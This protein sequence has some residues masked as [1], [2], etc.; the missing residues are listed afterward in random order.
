M[1]LVW[2][3][4]PHY[5]SISFALYQLNQ[6]AQHHSFDLTPTL[7]YE[8]SNKLRQI[9]QLLSNT[10]NTEVHRSANMPLYSVA[11]GLLLRCPSKLITEIVFSTDVYDETTLQLMC[12]WPKALICALRVKGHSHSHKS[13]RCYIENSSCSTN[14]T[15]VLKRNEFWFVDKPNSSLQNRTQ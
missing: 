3:D 11:L 10:Y 4:A 14:A 5:C 12:I 2:H 9:V 13:Q 8:T 1:C 6:K 7:C 15:P